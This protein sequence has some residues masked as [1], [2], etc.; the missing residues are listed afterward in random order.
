[1]QEWW[2]QHAI[3]ERVTGQAATN[4]ANFSVWAKWN[5]GWRGTLNAAG[6]VAGGAGTGAIGGALNT[7]DVL[8]FGGLDAAGDLVSGSSNWRDWRG[9]V[10]YSGGRDFAVAGR[11]L[12]LTAGTVGTAQVARGGIAGASWSANLINA[13]AS[14]NRTYNASRA[15]AMGMTTYDAAMGGYHVGNGAMRVYNGDNWGFLEMA[16]GGIQGFGALSSARQLAQPKLGGAYGD[17]RARGGEV[18]HA[19]A[20][21]ASPLIPRDS[22]A[23]RMEIADHA[24][25]ASYFSRKGAR[26]YIAAQRRLI[27]AGEFRLA[28]NMDI[29]DVRSKFGP[30]YNQ[31]IQEML[32]YINRIGK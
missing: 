7:T 28:V 11:E 9:G 10:D 29:A 6:K 25:T 26:A 22:P 4:Q 17:V 20:R 13:A 21:S 3:N 23:F 32:N 2:V 5:T 31:G 12:L 16:T 15:V 14:S 30:K 8:T 1:M 19:P 18:H 24:E 27:E